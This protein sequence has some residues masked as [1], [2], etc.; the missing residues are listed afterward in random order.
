MLS[1]SDWAMLLLTAVGYCCLLLIM[2]D[3]CYSYSFV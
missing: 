2:F 1:A 3:V